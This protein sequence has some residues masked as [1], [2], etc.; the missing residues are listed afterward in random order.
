MAGYLRRRRHEIAHGIGIQQRV[1]ERPAAASRRSR[2]RGAHQHAVP[3][4][5]ALGAQ[6]FGLFRRRGSRLYAQLSL[7]EAAQSRL[8]RRFGH[9]IGRRSL[10]KVIDDVALD[11]HVALLLAALL[12]RRQ[13]QRYR[14]RLGPS[15]ARPKHRAPAQ[16]RRWYARPETSAAGSASL[17]HQ[18]ADGRSLQAAQ[19]V[20]RSDP[21]ARELGVFL[22]LLLLLSS[23]CGCYQRPIDGAQLPTRQH[24]FQPVQRSGGVAEQLVDVDPL[25]AGPILDGSAQDVFVER[26]TPAPCRSHRC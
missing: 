26:W 12:T 6:L 7:L 23:C 20:P 16:Q 8:A 4:A 19:E 15:A 17:R 1:H 18:L 5:P 2:K 11:Q 25:D 13:S 22:L 21:A 10:R 24:L 14:R 3:P 9:R